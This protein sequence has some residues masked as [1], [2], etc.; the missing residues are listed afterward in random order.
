MVHE[1]LAKMDGSH[2]KTTG[3]FR[4][5]PNLG[6]NT[7]FG[8][9]VEDVEGHLIKSISFTDSRGIKYGPFTSISSLY[10]IV[11]YKVLNYPVGSRPPF[12]QV[13]RCKF[14]F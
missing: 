7:K 9:Y 8:V 3:K 14:L 1:K 2:R 6:R 4:I 5:D 13:R 12:D 10:D 11:N